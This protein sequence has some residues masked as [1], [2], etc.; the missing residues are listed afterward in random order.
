MTNLVP[1]NQLTLLKS[2]QPV[3]PSKAE[4]KKCKAG[5]T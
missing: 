3:Y 2:V 1:A 5:S 4:A